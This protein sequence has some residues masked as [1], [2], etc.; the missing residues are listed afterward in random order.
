[1]AGSGVGVKGRARR[2][3]PLVI[4]WREWVRLEGLECDVPVKAKVDSGAS[5]SA[6]HAPG[7]REFE[8]NGMTWASFILRPRQGS[9][10]DSRRVEAPVIGRRRVRSS[11]GRSELRPV[12]KTSIVIGDRKWLIEV[13]LTQR[14]KMRFRMLLGR[15]AFR[16]KA[17]VDVSRS[18]AAG[19][20][21]VT[22]PRLPRPADQARPTAPRSKKAA[23]ST[24][25]RSSSAKTAASTRARPSSTRTA[26][27]KPAKG[28]ARQVSG[29]EN[30]QASEPEETAP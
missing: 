22:E 26:A 10:A 9:T 8:R 17:V 19:Q 25:A 21:V 20:P 2:R 16:G 29:P 28:K 27:S 24:R 11:N 1:M 14:H 30:P 23:A 15:R 6:L 4:G 13:T 5:T 18:H 7:L 12:I 3:A